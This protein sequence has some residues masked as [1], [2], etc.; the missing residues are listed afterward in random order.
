[1]E[2]RDEK[3]EEA[4]L[5][6]FGVQLR[7]LREQRR[8]T[9]EEAE[10]RS[11]V[12]TSS[13]SAYER[14]EGNPTLRTVMLLAE[15]YQVPLSGLLR[16]QEQE[17]D[18]AQ[19]AS[20]CLLQC[21]EAMSGVLRRG[22]TQPELKRCAAECIGWLEKILR[23]DQTEGGHEDKVGTGRDEKSGAACPQDPEAARVSGRPS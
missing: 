14:G 17:P 20:A 8:M 2:R 6:D 10:A 21:I 11:G 13:L 4:L 22:A 9:L 15:S 5:R 18:C 23:P 12:S 7:W 1:M 19:T 3:R 16:E